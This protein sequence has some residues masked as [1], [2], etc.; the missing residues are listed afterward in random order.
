[1]LFIYFIIS[2]SQTAP[3]SSPNMNVPS[4]QG[5][6]DM[7]DPLLLAWKQK[8]MTQANGQMYQPMSNMG[9]QN[10]NIGFQPLNNLNNLNSMNPGQVMNSMGNLKVNPSIPNYQ[11]KQTENTINSFSPDNNN[12]MFQQLNDLKNQLNFMMV[13]FLF[14]KVECSQSQ[15]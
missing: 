15:G 6:N 4:F 1:M 5:L 12:N 13:C 3:S 2:S 14:F 10:A 7:N 8:H 9:N 11:F